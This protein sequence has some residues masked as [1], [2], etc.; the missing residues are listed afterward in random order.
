MSFADVACPAARS[1]APSLRPFRLGAAMCGLALLALA[2]CSDTKAFA[3]PCPQL[4]FL[5]EGADLARFN[6]PGRDITDLVVEARLDGVPAS[7]GACRWTDKTHTSV[8]VS[9]QVAMTVARGPAMQG[10]SAIIPW[11]VAVAQDRDILDRQVYALR[12]DF[13]SNVDHTGLV[14]QPVELKL[15]VSAEKSAAAY[16]VWI[17]LQLTP[18]ELQ[19]NRSHA[20]QRH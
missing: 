14:S 2:G 5:P 15:P 12:A 16:R 20:A 4:S 10:R 18:D 9:M 11:F 8:S 7:T 3:P 6:G 19:Y 13:P 17:S 1:L